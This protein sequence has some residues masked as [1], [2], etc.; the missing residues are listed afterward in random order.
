MTSTSWKRLIPESAPTLTDARLQLHH[1]AQLATAFGISY[2]PARDDDSHTN[3]EW[4][5]DRGAL[6]SRAVRDVRVS[7]VVADLALE[8]SGERLALHGRTI[9]Q[10]GEWI[11]SRLA[12]TGL[13]AGRYTQKRHYEIPDHELSH[14]RRFDADHGQLEQL[15]RWFA[16]AALHL[17]HVRSS[18]P[19]ASE[20]RCW[21]HHFDIATL[22]TVS[23]GRTVGVGLEPGDAYYDEP[24]FY[25]NMHPQPRAEALPA[26]EGGGHW[27]T[28]D[29]IGAVLP[30]SRLSGDAK[31]QDAQAAAFLADAI[32]QATQLV[33]R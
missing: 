14:G 16:N 8:M 29:W 15:G 26:L 10:G 17:E 27:H 19:G 11:R 3:L 24:Y 2:L 6:A 7:L 31:A 21:P 25:V 33:A 1:A 23:P 5:T 32:T 4:L 28:R 9:A 13:A 12:A 18:H 30:G 20:V 22:I